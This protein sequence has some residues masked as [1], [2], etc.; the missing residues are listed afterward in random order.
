MEKLGALRARLANIGQLA[1]VVGAMRIL[2]AVRL[3]QATELRPGADRYAE[4][5]AAALSQ[6]L[7][8]AGTDPPAR[9]PR[10]PALLLFAAE[11]GFVGVYA[12][13]LARSAVATP[14]P[15]LYAVGARG[16]RLLEE[17]GA[18][19]GWVLP[20]TPHAAGIPGL[21]RR[22]AEGLGERL[23]AGA[24]TELAVMFGRLGSG[25]H[26]QVATQRLLPPDFTRFRTS[27]ARVPPLHHLP[28]GRLLDAVV[29]EYLLAGLVHAATEALAAENAA[30]LQAMTTAADNVDRKLEELRARERVLRQEQITDELLDV[31]NGAEALRVDA[32]G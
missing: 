27:A 19:A 5:V 26:W 10:R 1:E 30:R 4:I 29:A 7:V 18:P 14:V 16:A 25:G 22:V 13:A 20:M 32:D 28:S 6:A 17:L 23:A 21:V 2:A 11:H 9:R 15:E 31:L 3:Q 12:E 8:V 24:F